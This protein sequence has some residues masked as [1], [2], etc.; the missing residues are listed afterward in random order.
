M[1][2]YSYTDKPGSPLGKELY[3]QQ[4][5]THSYVMEH[6]DNIH[7]WL[8]ED[9]KGQVGYVPVACLM[10]IVDETVQE[11]GCDKTRK[12]GQENNT[13]GTKIG[14]GRQG[15]ER[16]KSYSAGVIGGF[17]RNSRI[18]VGDSIVR[19]TDSRLGKG[20]ML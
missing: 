7:W 11:E 13:D 3:M 19:T 20:R 17:K 18:Y 5:A 8:A 16:R 1:A 2:M 4:G 9:N 6:E 12:E 10:T 15:G 14:E